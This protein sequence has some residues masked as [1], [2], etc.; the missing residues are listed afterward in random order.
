MARS[1]RLDRGLLEDPPRSDV[2]VSDELRNLSF[3]V[4]LPGDVAEGTLDAYAL[5]YVCEG[6]DGTCRYLRQDFRIP[7]RK[8]E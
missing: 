3:E 6:A 1:W 4:E 7:V 5:Y 2:A 8:P